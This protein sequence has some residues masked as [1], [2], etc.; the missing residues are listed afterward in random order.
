MLQIIQNLQTGTTSLIEVPCPLP[1]KGQI[2]IKSHFSLMSL[3]T[4]R[5]LVEFG[6]ASWIDKA[7]QQPDKVKQVL[8]K[9]KTDGLGPTIEVIKRKL[10]TPIPLGYSNVGEVI[11]VGEDVIEFKIGDR[12][13]SNGPHAEFVCV[14]QNLVAKIPE[15]VSY[16]SA[17]FTIIGAIGLQGIRL[18]N[19]TFGE[20]IVVIGLGLIGMITCQLLKANGCKVIGFDL[21]PDKIKLA[22]SLGVSAF[23]LEQSNDRISLIENLTLR[24]GA[25]GV[26]ITANS[27]SNDIIHEAAQMC[28]KRGRI[29]LVGVVGLELRRS[30]FYEKE[31]TFQVSCSYGP[32]RYDDTYEQKGIDYPIGYVRW[33]EKRNFEAVLNALEEGILKVDELISS[34]IP[35]ES[36]RVVY[37]EISESKNIATL[38]KYAE[39]KIPEKSTL[40][41]NR[42]IILKA[43][44]EC[45]GIIGAGNYTSSVVLPILKKYNAQI[46]YLCSAKGLT[47]S[48]LA[49]KYFIQ[50]ATSDYRILLEDSDVNTIIIT[51]RHN[52]HAQLVISALE[53]G[54]NVF[55]EKPLALTLM[56]LNQIEAAYKVSKGQLVV[57]FNRRFAPLAI[58]LRKLISG[59]DIPISVIA[60]MNAGP[61]PLDH[62]TTDQITGGGR[63][64]GEACHYFDLISSLTN[65]SINQVIMNSIDVDEDTASILLHYQNGSLGVI[66]YF[67]NGSKDYN[68]E[69][70]EVYSQGRT[71]II[72]NF[73]RLENFGFGRSSLSL[74]QDKGQD[75]QFKFFLDSIRHGGKAIIPIESILNTSKA[76]IGAVLSQKSRNWYEVK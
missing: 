29:I 9:I 52:T 43:G 42:N 73:K 25:D 61:L 3:G 74:K 30:D 45:I 59:M 19:P 13:V 28:R 8:Q 65:S 41:T 32:G 23:I 26:I 64:I 20:T 2:L 11:G 44:K 47:A 18:L 35:I 1:Q 5:M 21:D 14:P 54:K 17:S 22:Q 34:I 7:K 69:R 39:N 51:T 53:A 72:D 55:V 48:T 6:K 24:L 62:W 76:V 16:E 63:I 70:I 36:F 68:K 57:G 15:R 67:S 31:I 33:T 60:T 49:K 38:F 10:D 56:E 12:V 50:N 66:N 37:D 58:E 46:K 27:K 75:N 40:V 71:A 4:E